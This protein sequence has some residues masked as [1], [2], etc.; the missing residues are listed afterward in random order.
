M[1]TPLVARD[2]M[3]LRRAGLFISRGTDA[4]RLTK[5]YRSRLL[6]DSTQTERTSVSAVV[7][8]LGNSE[9][10]IQEKDECYARRTVLF[11]DVVKKLIGGALTQF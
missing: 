2:A 9:C 6:I 5:Q 4:S 8:V 10:P 3:R 1:R 11:T 7:E